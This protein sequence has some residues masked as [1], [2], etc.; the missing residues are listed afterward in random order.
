[1]HGPAL[2]TS[3]RVDGKTRHDY[4]PRRKGDLAKALVGRHTKLYRARA[5]IQKL[6]QELNGI[7]DQIVECRRVGFP[8]SK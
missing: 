1:M 6:N 3:R 5:Q 4:V 2:Y 8:E 7:L